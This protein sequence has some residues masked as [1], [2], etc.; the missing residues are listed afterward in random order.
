MIWWEKK[1]HISC[2][3]ILKVFHAPSMYS[4]AKRS[5]VLNDTSKEMET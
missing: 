3:N 2:A 1:E 5:F 4:A